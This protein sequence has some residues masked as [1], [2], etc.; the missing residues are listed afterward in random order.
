MAEYPMTKKP[1]P[2]GFTVSP[3]WNTV[4]E[5]YDSQN[6]QRKAKLSFAVYDVSLKYNALTL[7][8][9]QTLWAFYMARMGSYE[10]FYIY[11]LAVMA[12]TNLCVG[13]GDGTSNTWDLPGKSTSSQAIYVDGASLSETLE[14]SILTGG[15]AESADRVL[16][17]NAPADGAVITCDFTGYLRMKVRF[18]EDKLNRESFAYFLFHLG[19]EL[20]GLN[21]YTTGGGSTTSGGEGDNL[22]LPGSTDNLLLPD[23]ADGL[24]LPG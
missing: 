17:V 1:A 15:G 10:S 8:E 9:I 7:S 2:D 11:D 16:L 18:K 24:L 21:T 4:I 14:Y 13:I 12:H 3:R 5:K 20:V 6:E 22:L 19:L 23:S